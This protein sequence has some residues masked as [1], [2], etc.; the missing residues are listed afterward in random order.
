MSASLSLDPVILNAIKVILARIAPRVEVWAFGSR[1]KGFF[2]E[3]SD[4]DLVIRN[5]TELDKSTG[6]VTALKAAF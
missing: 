4:L 6:L 2:H 1:V 3:C 5:P